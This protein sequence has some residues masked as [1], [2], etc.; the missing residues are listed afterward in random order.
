MLKLKKIHGNRNIIIPTSTEIR[1]STSN[2]PTL[3]DIPVNLHF[4]LVFSSVFSNSFSIFFEAIL[5]MTNSCIWLLNEI[6]FK[7][8]IWNLNLRQEKFP[9]D[10]TIS[11]QSFFYHHKLAKNGCVNNL[12]DDNISLNSIQANNYESIENARCVSICAS[13]I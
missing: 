3:N 7:K 13:Q 2:F 10:Q 5:V 4:I 6:Y 11:F 1:N 12:I 8:F 9:L